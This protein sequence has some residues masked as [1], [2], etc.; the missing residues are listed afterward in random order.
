MPP[1]VKLAKGDICSQASGIPARMFEASRFLVGA[2]VV[3]RRNEHHMVSL[4]VFAAEHGFLLRFIELMPVS[5]TD[6]RTEEIFL[7]IGAARRRIE[8]HYGP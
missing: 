1:Q 2:E 8:E 4:I 3:R 6:F 7:S 5:T